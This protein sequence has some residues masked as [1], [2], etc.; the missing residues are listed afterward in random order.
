M[1]LSQWFHGSCLRV[2]T[3]IFPLRSD[4]KDLQE[5]N[6][7]ALRT[8][9][10][11]WYFELTPLENQHHHYGINMM[12]LYGF[13]YQTFFL[14]WWVKWTLELIT[15]IQLQKVLWKKQNFG[16]EPTVMDHQL[17][18][19]CPLINYQS[20]SLICCCCS[21]TVKCS[22]SSHNISRILFL[23]FFYLHLCICLILSK[24]D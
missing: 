2:W 12:T 23:C 19:W 18:F 24:F 14:T 9:V 10:Y 7:T 3:E 11:V 5:L 15:R 4:G 17:W 16:Q 20:S 13:D 22:H 1:Q 21:D 6:A 8:L